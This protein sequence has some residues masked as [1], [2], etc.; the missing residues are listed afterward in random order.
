MNRTGEPDPVYVRARRALLDALQALGP[1]RA[2]VV[3]VG[4]QA[5]YLHVGEAQEP[6][7]TP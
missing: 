1:H 3:L 4:A 6:V 5:V 7:V 2:A